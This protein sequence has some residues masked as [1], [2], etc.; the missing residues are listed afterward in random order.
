MTRRS[1]PPALLGL[2][3]A[4]YFS[5]A[6]ASALI[7]PCLPWQTLSHFESKRRKMGQ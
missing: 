6:Q 4:L 5:G 1:H 3:F 7:V 2:L